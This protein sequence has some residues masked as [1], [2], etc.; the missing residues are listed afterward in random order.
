MDNM[1]NPNALNN[2][3]FLL[4][5]N[6]DGAIAWQYSENP[7][8]RGRLA[9]EW[10]VAE[11]G[12]VGMVR[13]SVPDN[14]SAL[15][16]KLPVAINGNMYLLVDADGDFSSG[17]TEIPMMLNGTDWEA[18]VDFSNGQYFTFASEVPVA[19]GCVA[20][21]GLWLRADMG[22]TDNGTDV[23]E[24]LDPANGYA[25]VP[26]GAN[27]MPS[28]IAGSATTFNFNPSVNFDNTSDVLAAETAT[29]LAGSSDADFFY[30]MKAPLT[31]TRIFGVDHIPHSG[32]AIYD[33]PYLYPTFYGSRDAGGGQMPFGTFSPALNGPVIVGVFYD[34]DASGTTDMTTSEVNGIANASSAGEFEIGDGGYV[35]G[36]NAALGGDDAGFVGQIAEVIAYGTKLGT[37]QRQQIKSYLA[38]KYGM[39]LPQNYFSGTGNVIWDATANAAYSN[40]ITGIGRE[41]CQLLHQKQSKSINN[42]AFVT[43]GHGDIAD[44]NA[45]NTNDMSDGSF[46][47][48]GN[49]NGVVGYTTLLTGTSLNR[50]GRIWKVQ[51]T[52]T[53][54][55]VKVRIP[56]AN[57]RS[58]TL[59]R[60]TDATFDNTDTQV[61]MTCD[62]TGCWATINFNDGDYFTFAGIV[63]V[64]FSANFNDQF[65]GLTGEVPATPPT[66]CNTNFWDRSGVRTTGYTG[67]PGN[68]M[69]PGVT[70]NET[71]HLADVDNDGDLDIVWLWDANMVNSA[72]AGAYIW[73]GNNDGTFESA[74]TTYIGTLTAGG[75]PNGTN[76][77]GLGG[78]STHESTHVADVNGDGNVDLIWLFETHNK[79]Y[80]WLGN[81]NGTWQDEAVV[82]AGYTG[83]P[84]NILT[85]GISGNESTFLADVNTDGILDIVWVFDHGG[86]NAGG[87]Y[88]WFGLGDGTWQTAATV[89]I[90][91]FTGTP[92]H[93]M[94]GQT[95]AESTHLA[96]FTGDGIPDILWL[97]ESN[98][99]SYCWPGNG[100]GTFQHAAIVKNGY[101]GGPGNVMSIGYTANETTHIGDVDNDGILDILWT[102]DAGVTVP[103]AGVYIWR[104]IGNGTFQ[105][106]AVTD[107]GSLTSSGIFNGTGGGNPVALG[108]QSA[109]ESS[110]VADFNGDGAV[111][112]MWLYEPDNS[113]HVW[114]STD[115]DDD[116]ISDN[117]DDDD[118]G[119]AIPDVSDPCES[120]GGV[121]PT[122]ALWLRADEGTSS[123][124]NGNTLNQWE[125]QGPGGNN[126]SQPTAGERPTFQS[127]ATN[128]FNFNPVVKFTSTKNFL[129]YG[130]P[131]LDKNAYTIFT[132]NRR[133]G[134]S[135][136]AGIFSQNRGASAGRP[137]TTYILNSN[138]IGLNG[139]NQNNTNV[140]VT[141]PLTGHILLRNMGSA[142]NNL[143]ITMN[144]GTP[145]ASGTYP[146]TPGGTVAGY[147]IGRHN[148]N[149]SYTLT[150][151]I[152]EVIAY[153]SALSGAQV[154]AVET[155]LGLKYGLTLGHNYVASDNTVI[156]DVAANAA[157]SNDIA[158]IGRDDISALQ[159]KQSKSAGTDALVT[160]GNGAIEADNWT[161]TNTFTNDLTYML[162][163]NNNGVF[164]TWTNSGS[165][166]AYNRIARAWKV[167]RNRHRW[168]RQTPRARQ[169]QLAQ[170]K[171]AHR[172]RQRLPA[173]GCRRRF[174]HR[175][176]DHG[177]DAE[178]Y[179]LG[180][181]LQFQRWPVFH[182]HHCLCAAHAQH[183]AG[184]LY[185]MPRHQH[186]FLR[187]GFGK[188]PLLSMAGK[189]GRRRQFCQPRR[190]YQQHAGHSSGEQLQIPRTAGRRLWPK[191]HFGRSNCHAAASAGN[192]HQPDECD[193]LLRQQR[194]LQRGGYRH[195][196]HLPMA[197]KPGRRF[198]LGKSF[199]SKQRFT[200]F[201]RRD[202]GHEWSPVPRRR[203]RHL[204]ASCHLNSGDTD[205]QQ[206]THDH[207]ATSQRNSLPRQHGYV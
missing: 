31:G 33:N 158:G 27:P 145:T 81:G 38:I 113:S 138:D 75:L 34:D 108:G 131:F 61:P 43:I 10:R 28:P 184:G 200:Y 132:V 121:F 174:H 44:D 15:S 186:E 179:E 135:T 37:A 187:D 149:L 90:G 29:P 204:Y 14:S 165:A 144:G 125:D 104:G 4:W 194:P 178:R 115:R 146:G 176:Y 150:G 21:V 190:R 18:D 201:E 58:L 188:Q 62:E 159:Q 206:R 39:T 133:D 24:W 153:S 57:I 117:T 20:G 154:N 148:D 56:S 32:G 72:A 152:A 169:Q 12:T 77:I 129:N 2:G 195:R 139:I 17:A 130:M 87:V 102:W 16:S 25:T 122:L 112:L 65:D 96:D 35:L 54:G 193:C 173:D 1:S 137:G 22:V 71:T 13:L 147:Y 6:N 64:P 85:P 109:S 48:L 172:N 124:T 198:Q 99:V 151:N 36:R 50:M 107:L 175:C 82:K 93:F 162:W 53:V 106:A 183:R 60:S 88:T 120:P 45:G 202:I 51:E 191:G 40:N 103:T 123:T 73:K 180:I 49:N 167:G 23:V 140:G 166:P 181:R 118:D 163:G 74:A 134:A 79:S 83:G 69:T 95:A 70:A 78:V 128:L 97:W 119:D 192:Y 143:S 189:P 105:T 161:N 164:N 66:R 8:G 110:H 205:R 168:R 199:G 7:S 207:H 92:G 111:D 80:T 203:E 101:T 94:G 5:G 55:T 9:R 86:A 89:D 11:K 197:G 155:Y 63:G 76:G 26:V 171:I 157:Y 68:I 19:P 100:D 136:W 47:L 52:G 67:G 42:G 185:R 46:L 126:A 156:W 196:Y 98:N 91:T 127:D 41:D 160:I 84:G 142:G 3:A 182:L 116:G 170:H 59:V 114:L 141:D 177:Y 30:V